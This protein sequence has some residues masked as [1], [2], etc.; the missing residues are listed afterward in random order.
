MMTL[1]YDDY[2]WSNVDGGSTA[3]RQLRAMLA[4]LTRAKMPCGWIAEFTRAG[5]L[6]YHLFVPRG[7]LLD[8]QECRTVVR[9]GQQTIVNCGQLERHLVEAWCRIAGIQDERFQRGG[10]IES[11]RSPDAA[12]RYVAK[13]CSKRAQK[14]CPDG[15]ELGRWWGLSASLKPTCRHEETVVDDGSLPPFRLSFNA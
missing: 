11:L 9:S 12:A 5:R 13:E 15:F 3:K 1:T 10:I 8:S 4:V 14:V 6:H 2:A 7:T